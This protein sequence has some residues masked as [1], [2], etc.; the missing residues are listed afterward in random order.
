MCTIIALG[1]WEFIWITVCL[2]AGVLVGAVLMYCSLLDTKVSKQT[3]VRV[4]EVPVLGLLVSAVSYE[5]AGPGVLSLSLCFLP[6]KWSRSSSALTLS[7]HLGQAA[8][9]PAGHPSLGQVGQW[10]AQCRC[11]HN[12]Q[13][14]QTITYSLT[15]ALSGLSQ[16]NSYFLIW[17]NNIVIGSENLRDRDYYSFIFWLN[18]DRWKNSKTF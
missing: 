13:S 2:L 1:V 6:W 10:V 5:V 9:S 3:R 7:H 17:H 18:K 11:K 12:Y 16:I 8:S 14:E 15:P 4:M